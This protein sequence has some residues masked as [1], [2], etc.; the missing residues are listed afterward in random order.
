MAVLHNL[1]RNPI[2]GESIEFNDNRL[3]LYSAQKGKCAVTGKQMEADE[4][5]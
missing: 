1:M 4:V 2:D 3:S 5:I